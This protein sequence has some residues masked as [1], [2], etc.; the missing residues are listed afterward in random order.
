MTDEK[1]TF[2][3]MYVPVNPYLHETLDL[4]VGKYFKK[5]WNDFKEINIRNFENIGIEHAEVNNDVNL[6]SV[7]ILL[8]RIYNDWIAYLHSQNKFH[9]DG[10]YLVFRDYLLSSNS[11]FYENFEC[12]RKLSRPIRLFFHSPSAGAHVPI[13]TF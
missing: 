9:Y 2:S 8:S 12:I 10:I 3:S 1:L 5:H 11:Y 6:R 13:R 7:I 4:Y